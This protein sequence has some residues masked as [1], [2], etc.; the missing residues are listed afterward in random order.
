L[1][2]PADSQNGFQGYSPQAI[3]MRTTIEQIH[4]S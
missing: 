4:V 2:C 1:G 3:S